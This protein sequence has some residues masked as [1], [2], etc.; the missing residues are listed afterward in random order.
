MWTCAGGPADDE[1]GKGSWL[2]VTSLFVQVGAHST[3]EGRDS[4]I[5]M[6]NTLRLELIE[7]AACHASSP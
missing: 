4:K 1:E 7:G 6:K 2:G 3:T 5:D